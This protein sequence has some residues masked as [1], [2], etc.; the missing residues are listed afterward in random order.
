M[1][2]TKRAKAK[3]AK[4]EFVEANMAKSK[5]A[6]S[7]IV[8]ASFANTEIAIDN[9]AEAKFAKQHLPHLKSQRLHYQEGTQQKC[10]RAKAKRCKKNTTE[11]KNVKRMQKNEE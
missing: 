4:N 11:M 10:R 5:S 9:I 1:S 8:R 7:R 6:K 3:C 2:K